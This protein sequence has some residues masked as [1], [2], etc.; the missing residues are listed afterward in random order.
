[1]ITF[2]MAGWSFYEINGMDK[3]TIEN[4]GIFGP[5]RIPLMVLGFI[6]HC[7]WIQFNVYIGSVD[8]VDEQTGVSHFY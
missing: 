4:L 2:S 8:Y 5:I 3:I 6:V 1:V 7:F